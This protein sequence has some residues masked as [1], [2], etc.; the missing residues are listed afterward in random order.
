MVEKLSLTGTVYK[1][2]DTK[3]V[4]ETFTKRDFVI[5][6]TDDKYPQKVKFELTQD[7]CSLADKLK[8]GESV[9][10][11]FNVRGREWKNEEKREWVYFVSLNAWRIEAKSSEIEPM[12]ETKK[13]VPT[14]GGDDL[15]F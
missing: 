5:E 6:T 13:E 4:T 14:T 3:R 8:D 7:N 11:H 10:V 15:P 12:P 1:I 2:F 9:E